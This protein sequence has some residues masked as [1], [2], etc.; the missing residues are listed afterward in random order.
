[1]GGEQ[2]GNPVERRPIEAVLAEHTDDLMALPGVVGT[3]QG[4]CEGVPCIRVF[5]AQS[6]DTLLQQVPSM[7][8][9]YTV[10]VQE[11]GE[12]RALDPK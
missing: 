3:G 7:L 2:E 11:T 6:T 5:V 9:G 10:E 4:E 12:F 8:E 1:M